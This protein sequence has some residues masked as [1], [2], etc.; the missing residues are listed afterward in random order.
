MSNPP[1]YTWHTPQSDPN[2]PTPMPASPTLATGSTLCN[3]YKW[4]LQ[5]PAPPVPGGPK[6][7]PTP[8]TWPWGQ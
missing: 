4:P 8:T 3:P 1:D 2:L 5:F 7:P 6:P